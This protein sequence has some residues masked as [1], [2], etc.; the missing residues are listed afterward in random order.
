MYHITAR[1]QETS[2][3]LNAINIFSIVP[4]LPRSLQ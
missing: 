4:S 3:L 2:V 1:L